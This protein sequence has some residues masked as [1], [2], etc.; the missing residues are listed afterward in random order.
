MGIIAVSWKTRSKVTLLKCL[1][2]CCTTQKYDAIF[3]LTGRQLIFFQLNSRTQ[4]CL[5]QNVPLK[6]YLTECLTQKVTLKMSHSKCLTKIFLTHTMFHSKCLI[7]N[8]L[9]KMSHSK[10]FFKSSEV[11][12][13]VVYLSSWCYLERKLQHFYRYSMTTFP[14][15][16]G[17]YS[18][19]AV[20]LQVVHFYSCTIVQQLDNYRKPN[21]IRMTEFLTFFDH[22]WNRVRFS[23]SSM[24][25][26]SSMAYQSTLRWMFEPS[27]MTGT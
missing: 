25:F 6:I 2:D 19:F 22:L 9:L 5:I 26:L 20:L 21:A 15:K 10:I 7:Y 1:I 18:L 17:N 16:K 27:T 13:S 11:W 23:R 14:Y 4:K 24:C 3:L 8:V 12:S